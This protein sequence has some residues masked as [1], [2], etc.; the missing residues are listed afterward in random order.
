MVAASDP[1]Q[2]ALRLTPAAVCTGAAAPP[3]PHQRIR[4]GSA[5]SLTA[6]CGRLRGAPDPLLRAAGAAAAASAQRWP[7]RRSWASNSSRVAITGATDMFGPDRSG[8]GAAPRGGGGFRAASDGDVSAP[9]GSAALDCVSDAPSGGGA[10]A[11]S[12]GGGGTGAA[13]IAVPNGDG[14]GVPRFAASASWSAAQAAPLDGDGS[15]VQLGVGRPD[16]LQARWRCHAAE[17]LGLAG[18][19]APPIPAGAPGESAT[20]QPTPTGPTL[21]LAKTL[22]LHSPLGRPNSPSPPP[23]GYG[24]RGGDAA[25]LRG[26][27]SRSRLRPRSSACP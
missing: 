26:P 22:E 14:I 8:G 4:R 1:T 25:G 3:L 27:S 7:T 10:G 15:L 23:C 17:P 5:E 2:A 11:G 16:A 24:R 6:L 12:G 13:S 9:D 19:S 18:A 20:E 21:A